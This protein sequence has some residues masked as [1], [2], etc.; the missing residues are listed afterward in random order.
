LD[1]G[2]P[3]DSDAQAS[4]LHDAHQSERLVEGEVFA[5]SC[6]APDFW[7]RRN[8]RRD[9]LRG[10]ASENKPQRCAEPARNQACRR[11][12]VRRLC[13][14]NV[15]GAGSLDCPCQTSW[16]NKVSRE[17]CSFAAEWSKNYGRDRLEVAILA[18]CVSVPADFSS[19][20][21]SLARFG[22]A[23]TLAG[24]RRSMTRL[25]LLHFEAR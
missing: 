11:N 13:V 12:H 15:I 14:Q 9:R 24:S 4:T 5:V 21:I 17:R 3:N 2:L 8:E 22:S 23:G 16:E 7:H 6:L 10:A 19:S 18:K 25:G 20:A 1:G